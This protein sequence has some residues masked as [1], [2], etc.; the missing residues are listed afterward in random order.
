MEWR[1]RESSHGG[2]VAECGIPREGG[3][4]ITSAGVTMPCFFVY[5]S[6]NFPTLKQA[7]RYVKNEEAKNKRY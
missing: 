6:T 3:V 1:I 4:Q 2:F 7:E 5:R